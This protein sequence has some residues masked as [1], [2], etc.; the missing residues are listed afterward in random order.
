MITC[1]MS[2]LRSLYLIDSD[3]AKARTRLRQITDPEERIALSPFHRYE[4]PN[5][6]RLSVF[7][8]LR[9]AAAGDAILAAFQADLTDARFELPTCNLASLLIEAERLSSIYTMD[10]GYRAFDFLHVAAALQFEANE[11]L[12]FD[13]KQSRLA[14]A[15]GLR[16]WP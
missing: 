2:F 14:L 7:R 4:L 11:F 16:P 8:G 1:D 5:A 10:G 13:A 12:T 3:T 9:D 6:I 15:V